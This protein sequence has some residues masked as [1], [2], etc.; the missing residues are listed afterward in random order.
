[1]SKRPRLKPSYPLILQLFEPDAPSED[2]STIHRARFIDQ[3]LIRTADK[4]LTTVL[5]TLIGPVNPFFR[6]D[7]DLEHGEI[8]IADGTSFELAVTVSPQW[9]AVLTFKS[10][11]MIM[12]PI[13]PD[14]AKLDSRLKFTNK[15]ISEQDSEENRMRLKPDYHLVQ[16]NHPERKRRPPM[17]EASAPVS[18]LLAA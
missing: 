15:P 13:R 1:M 6:I 10:H 14:V 17:V 5:W 4:R 7:P 8:V 16:L 12:V 2:G 11:T 3:Q 9:I 18:K